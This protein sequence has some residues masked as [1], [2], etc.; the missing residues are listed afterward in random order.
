MDQ[1]NNNATSVII[2]PEPLVFEPFDFRDRTPQQIA[3]A[4]TA[5]AEFHHIEL[6]ERDETLLRDVAFGLG[7]R[8]V[9]SKI[10][11]HWAGAFSG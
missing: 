8:V 3:D 9:T 6:S 5:W 4:I 7:C 11:R 2:P 10:K 1:Q